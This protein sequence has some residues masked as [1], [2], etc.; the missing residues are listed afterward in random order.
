M[1]TRVIENPEEYTDKPVYPEILDLSYEAKRARK[2]QELYE[3]F[4]KVGTVEEKLIKINLPRYYGF[5]SLMLAEDYLPYNCL[6]F[7]RHVTRTDLIELEGLPEYYKQHAEAAKAV[8][9]R[10]KGDVQDIIGFE[11]LETPK[12]INSEDPVE[13]EEI[14]AGKIV[15]QLNRL[16]LAALQ[17]EQPHLGEVEVDVDPR[18]EAFWVVGGFD[19]TENVRRYRR[20]MDWTKKYENDPTDRYLQYVGSPYV[21]L[22][23]QHPLP[24]LVEVDLDKQNVVEDKVEIPPYR[25]DP[26]TLGFTTEYRHGTTIP[27]FWPGNP[28]EF[29]VISFQRRHHFVARMLRDH[30]EALHAHGLLSTFAWLFGQ[31]SYQGFTPYTEITY[32]LTAQTVIT[33]GRQF[34]FYAY[35][36]NTLLLCDHNATTNPRY[37]QCWATKEQKLFEEVD[38][39]GKVVGFNEDVLRSLIHFYLNQPQQ[40][41]DEMKPYL[42]EGTIS[43]LDD[44]KR[45]HFLETRFK[46]LF[47]IRPRYNRIPETF[48]WEK[49]YKIDHKTRPMDK[50]VLPSGFKYNPF[51]RR[52]DDH[53]PVYVPRVL[54]PGGYGNR[55]Y[56]KSKEKWEPTYYP[57]GAKG[58]KKK[59]PNYPWIPLTN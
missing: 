40:R 13:R 14:I 20:G 48:L 23:H 42:V 32:P 3:E 24:P 10:V 19:P 5:Q 39:T 47:S 53:L 59:V 43:Q 34:S 49:I 27:G 25:L 11:Y 55:R 35:Q 22:R 30:Q 52:L 28:N 4:K 1:A 9:E 8:V 37:N 17:Q 50:I 56:G 54:R 58:Q 38:E 6:D 41:S 21:A 45:R 44:P 2:K 15:V 51:Q 26:R 12:Q 18:H 57:L 46:H 33:D 7:M 16:L 36:M 31:A 29:G